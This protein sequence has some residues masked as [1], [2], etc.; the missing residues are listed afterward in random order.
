MTTV[1]RA[2]DTGAD[3]AGLAGADAAGLAGADAAGLAGEDAAG[4]AGADAAGLAGADAAGLA[5]VDFAGVDGARSSRALEGAGVD[6]A[7]VAFAGVD[8]AGFAGVD[9]AGAEDEDFGPACPPDLAICCGGIRQ[10]PD[11]DQTDHPAAPV[12]ATQTSAAEAP[13]ADP[14]T[15]QT[16][17]HSASAKA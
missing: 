17:G 7:G 8:A 9:F 11:E 5:G 1:G 12:G 10:T 16:A 13:L 4:L 2:V 6:F 15:S 14:E 3:A